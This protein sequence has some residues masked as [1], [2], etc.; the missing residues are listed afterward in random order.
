M[1]LEALEHVF[2]VVRRRIKAHHKA[3][4]GGPDGVLPRLHPLARKLQAVALENVREHPIHPDRELEAKPRGVAQH[5][6]DRARH[7]VRPVGDHHGR[8]VGDVVG[9]QRVLDVP[10]LDDAEVDARRGPDLQRGQA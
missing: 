10:Q 6:R 1:E 3:L 9:K 8:V 2:I 4:S 7:G 5:A